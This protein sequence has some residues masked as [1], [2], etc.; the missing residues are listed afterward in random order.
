[1]TFNKKLKTAAR[2]YM[3]PVCEACSLDAGA[4]ICDSLTDASTDDWVYD[5]N[6]F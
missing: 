6:G 2:P 1:M 3:A 4:V 5:E